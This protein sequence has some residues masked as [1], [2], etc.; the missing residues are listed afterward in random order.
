MLRCGATHAEASFASAIFG[1]HGGLS[2][3]SFV[4]VN[5]ILRRS[6]ASR[7]NQVVRPRLLRVRRWQGFFAGREHPSATLSDLGAYGS[8]RSP[9]NGGMEE[10]GLDCFSIFSPRVF[11]VKPMAL[12]SNT[13]LCSVSV[14]KGPMWKLY[15]PR[16]MS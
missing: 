16:V 7:G 8:W 6:L 9:A 15:L 11:Y 10:L 2:Y 12:S 14:V 13:W 3:S 1:R 5:R 4:E